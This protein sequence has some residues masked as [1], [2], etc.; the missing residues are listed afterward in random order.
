[1]RVLVP[2]TLG[3]VLAPASAEA[4]CLS[5]TRQDFVPTDEQ[6]CDTQGKPL[7]WASRC[8]DVF[9]HD[10]ASVQVDVAT[11]RR[12]LAEGF[13]TWAAVRCPADPVACTG[14]LGG[15][16]SLVAREAGSTACAAGFENTGGNSNVVAFLDKNWPH[17][18]GAIALTTVSFRTGTGEILD[19]DIEVDSD[20]STILLSTGAPKPGHYD[21]ESIL[22]HESGHL[23][24]LTHTQPAHTEAAMRPRYDPGDISLRTL[25]PD[26]ECGLCASAPP[27]R[28]AAC[29]PGNAATC[30]AST[31]TPEPEPPRA[32]HPGCS[33]GRTKG[34]TDALALGLLLLVS[35]V[36]RGTG[37]ARRS[38]RSRYSR[39]SR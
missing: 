36:R 1:M 14:A 26:D 25:A 16:P 31:P 12:L 33:F 7:F 2:L 3:L 22:V 39:C 6:P 21:V 9:V 4:Y 30:G 5:T 17:E 32:H 29:Q 15:A 8:V 20:P 19:A 10:P 38:P 11:A 35:R 28:T 24:G 13:A 23:L 37:W 18:P 34:G 27:D